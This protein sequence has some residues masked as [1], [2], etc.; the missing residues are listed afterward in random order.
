V[1]TLL[2]LLGLAGCPR[3]SQELVE[4][5]RQIAAGDAQGTKRGTLLEKR[6]ALLEKMG[7]TAEAA[8]AYEQAAAAYNQSPEGSNQPVLR[9]EHA[10]QQADRLR[11]K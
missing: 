3:Q 4:I 9:A 8:D 11:R 6:G 1:K 7:R 5:D 10:R 2:L